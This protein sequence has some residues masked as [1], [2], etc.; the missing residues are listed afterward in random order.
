MR[1]TPFGLRYGLIGAGLLV[2]IAAGVLASVPSLLEPWLHRHRHPLEELSTIRVKRIDLSVM[3]SAGG[4]VDSS[5]KTTIECELENV[6]IRVR[7]Q[8][9]SGGGVSTIL[10]VLPEGSEVKKGDVLCVLDAS[11]Y[12]ELARTQQMSVDRARAD[13][14]QAELNLEV[15]KLGVQEYR[16]GIMVQQVKTLEGLIALQHAD[17]ER[18]TDRLAW[19]KRMLKK[20][21]LAQSQFSS[22]QYQ[23]DRAAMA[24]DQGRTA[25]W[26][27]NKY[28]APKYLYILQSDIVGAEAILTYQDRRLQRHEF[29]LDFLKRQIDHCTIRAP[30]DGFLIYAN[31]ERRLVQIEPG[32]IVRQRQRLFFLPNLARMEVDALVHETMVKHVAPGMRAW[33][34]VESLSDRVMEGHVE[35]VAP[36]PEQNFFSEVKYYVAAVKLDS[37]PKG[38]KPGMTAEVEI[39]TLH[40]PDVLAIPSDALTY[41]DGQGFC[42]VAHADHLERRHVTVGQA[43]RDMLE[44]TEG[45]DEGDAVVIDPEQVAPHTEIVESELAHDSH[46][47]AGAE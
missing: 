16:D 37:V 25:L 39:Q 34:R 23:R 40:R 17:W 18:A 42:Y 22:D 9:I 13:H 26:L 41:E 7:G 30:H 14:L 6:D 11:D 20:G 28:S 31:D 1:R 10:S 35:S 19:S 36:L 27:F 21:Y 46:A 4:R 45:L 43:S 2:A 33:V 8:E 44:V 3:T 15:A 38:L 29:R 12:E 5:E 24:L 32:L 47:A